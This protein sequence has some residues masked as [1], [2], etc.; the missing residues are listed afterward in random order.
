LAYRF[1]GKMKQVAI[2]K[3]PHVSLANARLQHA[4]ARQLLASGVDPMVVRKEVKEQKK[5]EKVESAIAD[6]MVTVFGLLANL[7]SYPDTL[8]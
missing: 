4:Q 8:G 6:D 2:G 3:Y 5:V 1:D 7:N